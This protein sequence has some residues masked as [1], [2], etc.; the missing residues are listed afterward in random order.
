MKLFFAVLRAFVLAPPKLFTMHDVGNMGCWSG[1]QYFTDRYFDTALSYIVY[2]RRHT[3]GS[4]DALGW[5][6][7]GWYDSLFGFGSSNS[8][9]SI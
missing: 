6:I 3:A 5:A 9:G 1:H 4:Y 7:S 8:V 2:L